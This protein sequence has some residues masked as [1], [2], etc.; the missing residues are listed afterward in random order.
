MSG[1]FNS[2][3]TK[4]AQDVLKPEQFQRYQQLN[5]QHQGLNAFND[6]AVQ[7]KLNL[8]A[9]Q[10]TKVE[11]VRL[12][13]N[14]ALTEILNKYGTDPT[15]AVSQFQLLRKQ[16]QDQLNQILND[17]QRQAWGQLTGEPIDFTPEAYRPPTK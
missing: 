10:M 15:T 13:Q 9:D 2:Q 6:P 17:Q 1:A 7:A 8:N 4:S 11:A 16:T 14:Q 12:R 5:W 3:V